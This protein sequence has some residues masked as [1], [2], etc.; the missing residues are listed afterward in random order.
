MKH[1]LLEIIPKLRSL[2]VSAEEL[3]ENNNENVMQDLNGGQN[4]HRLKKRKRRRN[5]NVDFVVIGVGLPRT[6]TLS[7]KAALQILTKGKMYH[8]AEV[9]R[10]GEED[11]AFWLRALDDPSGI[12]TSEWTEFFSNY[13][14]GMDA[15]VSFFYEEIMAAFPNVKVIL[16]SRNPHTWIDSVKETILPLIRSYDQYPVNWFLEKVLRVPRIRRLQ[17]DLQKKKFDGID[18]TFWDVMFSK[19]DDEGARMARTFY[20]QWTDKVKRTIP[21][22][23]L[24]EFDVK[25]G[26]QPL[27]KFLNVPTPKCEFPRANGRDQFK[28]MITALKFFSNLAVLGAP[29][30]VAALSLSTVWV[31]NHEHESDTSSMMSWF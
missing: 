25:Q 1:L 7:L 10:N 5:K 30:F 17:T 16:T 15:P 18:S 8:M 9:V 3:D 14:G 31:K 13:S 24:L 11:A 20:D 22:D 27:C 19:N 26:W 28:T 2:N 4:V 6:G 29:V 23:R 12:S 21:A